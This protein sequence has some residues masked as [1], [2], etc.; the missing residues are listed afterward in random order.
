MKV[1]VTGASGFIGYYVIHELLARGITVIA[2][3]I[4]RNIA[5]KKDWFPAV[6][7]VEHIIDDESNPSLFQK[8][9]QPDSLIHLAWKG[10]PNYKSLFHIEE[11]LPQQYA[12]LKNVVT[13]GL[14][15]MTVAGTCFE[16][17]MKTG[18]LS[19][20]TLPEP[21]NPYAL[22]K[23]TLRLF[24]EELK[25]H[26]PFILKWPRLF[27]LYGKGQNPN[28]LFS[29]LEK[30]LQNG[31]ESFNMSGGQQVRDYLPITKAATGLVDITLQ[32][33]ISGIINC[34]SN[35]P[36]TVMEMV[37]SFIKKANK[38]IRLNV[39]FYPYPDFEPMEFWGN[40]DKLL[41]IQKK[42]TSER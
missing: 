4:D 5:E 15:D 24:L 34:C 7:F 25:K 36:V 1:L 16:Y 33:E 21:A 14:K 3:D 10:L 38:Q 42:Y 18:C 6:T 27:Y 8:F 39:G 41:Q 17:G 32:T 19:E 2:T 37:T 13:G 23:N 28:S 31:D 30:A 9:H 29:Q 26:Q 35:E 22:A 11:N 12:F 40:N 20:D